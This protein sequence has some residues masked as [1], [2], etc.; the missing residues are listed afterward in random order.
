MP[1]TR[2]MIVHIVLGTILVLV[3]NTVGKFFLA[4]V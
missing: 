2:T 1:V 4:T 3:T